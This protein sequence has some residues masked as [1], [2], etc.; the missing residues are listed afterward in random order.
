MF[1]LHL[2]LVQISDSA[3]RSGILDRRNVRNTSDSLIDKHVTGLLS[4][5]VIKFPLHI[6][7]TY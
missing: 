4:Y 7:I 5:Y 6:L 2:S 3:F 1:L